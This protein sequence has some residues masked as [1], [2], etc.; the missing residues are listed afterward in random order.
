MERVGESVAAP[1]L[2]SNSHNP[3]GSDFAQGKGASVENIETMK[4]SKLDRFAEIETEARKLA[5]SGDYRGFA[6]IQAA[7]LERGFAEASRLSRNRWTCLELDRLCQQ[8]RFNTRP[9]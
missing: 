3:T 8:A 4:S 7:L 2:V 1:A 6:S 5:R 9:K